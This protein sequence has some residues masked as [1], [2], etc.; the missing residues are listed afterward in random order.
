M[1][2]SHNHNLSRKSNKLNAKIDQL[3]DFMRLKITH[4]INPLI[5]RKQKLLA[6]SNRQL[7]KVSHNLHK[8]HLLTTKRIYD[9]DRK[10]REVLIHTCKNLL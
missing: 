5:Y 7:N 1:V 6:R 8:P 10:E 3:K 4:R 9:K 2:I